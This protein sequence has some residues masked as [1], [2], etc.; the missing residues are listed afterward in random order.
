MV[1]TNKLVS[2]MDATHDIVSGVNFWP[3]FGGTIMKNGYD[4]W[5]QLI[6]LSPQ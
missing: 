6:C 4:R 3:F 2:N 1:T 5:M